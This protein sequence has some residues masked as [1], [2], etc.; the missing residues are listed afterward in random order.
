MRD[1]VRLLEVLW[2]LEKR[3]VGTPAALSELDA[4][5]EAN[6]G[7]LIISWVFVSERII[8]NSGMCAVGS[9]SSDV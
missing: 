2:R 6:E 1:L 4:I 7:G 3:L 9:S 8:V 5:S